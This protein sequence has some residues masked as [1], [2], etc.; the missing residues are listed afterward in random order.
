MTMATMSYPTSLRGA[1]TGFTQIGVRLGA[2]AGLVFWPLATAAFGTKALLVLAAVPA[3]A[4]IV[5]LVNK[6]DPHGRDIDAEDYDAE[7]SPV[8]A[9]SK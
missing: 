7:Q 2:I 4:I 6:W 8:M 3:I 5:I 9:Q 1:G